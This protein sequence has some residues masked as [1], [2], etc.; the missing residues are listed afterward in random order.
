L[1]QDMSAGEDRAVM[2]APEA[3]A[4]EFQS[5]GVIDMLEKLL[6]E[7]IAKRTE[8]E[9]K[10]MESKHAYEMLISDLESMI[11]KAESDKTK[12]EEDKAHELQVK[13]D[14]ETDLTETTDVMTADIKY[15]KDVDATCAQKSAD[16][17][18]RQKLRADELDAIAEA[19]EIISSEAVS[20]NAD[21]YLPT[22]LQETSKG[23][24][25]SIRNA[26]CC[27]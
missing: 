19:I 12:A 9:K 15:K 10:E 22:M 11:S 26:T 13:A 7:F 3:N 6:D 1:A 17:E 8:L 5:T 24:K 20:G 23:K 18:S 21:T 25:N 16:F 4:Y 2:A 14:A 27:N